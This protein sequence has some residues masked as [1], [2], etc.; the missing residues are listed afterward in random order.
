MLAKIVRQSAS[1]HKEELLDFI[2]QQLLRKDLN[3]QE[4]RD[5]RK[6]DNQT[7]SERIQYIVGLLC[8]L[9]GS[10]TV[11]EVAALP[12]CAL[13]PEQ[14]SGA[15][16]TAFNDG[17]VERYADDKHLIIYRVIEE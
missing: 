17:Q 7:R 15:L 4:K 8:E 2:Q 14:V 9:G 6:F 11:S 10:G 13:T 5:K 1:P 3:L 12:S 16:K